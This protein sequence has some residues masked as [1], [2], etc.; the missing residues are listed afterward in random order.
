MSD[1]LGPK[2]VMRAMGEAHRNNDLAAAVRYIAAESL[3]QGQPVTRED[4]LRKWEQMRAGSPDLQMITQHSMED[5][6][7]LAHRYTIRGTHTAALFGL[8]PTGKPFEVRGMDMVRVRD[9]HIVEHWA[10][11]DSLGVR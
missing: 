3:D 1:P 9:G 7:W 8:P 5:G 2:A 6:E 11:I 10:L 4:W